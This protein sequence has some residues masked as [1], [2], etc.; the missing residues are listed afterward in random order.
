MKEEE[1]LTEKIKSLNLAEETAAL[2]VVQRE[3]RANLLVNLN[4]VKVTK[5]RMAFQR[6]NVIGF[7]DG[8][9][10]TNYFH[11]I[12]NA[13]KRRNCI[14]KIEFAGVDVFN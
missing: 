13:K 8:D 2:S 5:A 7:K 1:E 9:K 4:N 10:N 3:E 14:S 11:K 6:A 12:A